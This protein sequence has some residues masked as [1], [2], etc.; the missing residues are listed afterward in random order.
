VAHRG[1]PGEIWE[2]GLSDLSRNRDY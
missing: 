1:R 2:E